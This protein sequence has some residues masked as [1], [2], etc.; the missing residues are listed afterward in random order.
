MSTDWGRETTEG[1]HIWQGLASP[2]LRIDAHPGQGAHYYGLPGC[3][4]IM[5]QGLKARPCR[6]EHDHTGP[7]SAADEAGPYGE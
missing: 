4:H 6:R 7:H 2:M 3:A 5:G 1:S